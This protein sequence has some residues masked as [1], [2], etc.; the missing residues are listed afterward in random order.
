MK[1]YKTELKRSN[2][3]LSKYNLI[4][5]RLNSLLPTHNELPTFPDTIESNFS[6]NIESYILFFKAIINKKRKMKIIINLSKKIRNKLIKNNINVSQLYLE[7]NKDKLK[8]LEKNTLE[9][10]ILNMNHQL[11]I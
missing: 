6:D 2:E 4:L 9:K 10:Y 5:D 7:E 1:S 8:D 3:E 11:S